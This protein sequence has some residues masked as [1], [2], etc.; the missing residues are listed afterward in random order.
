[1]RPGGTGGR[2]AVRT[3]PW[4]LA[5]ASLGACGGDKSSATGP[6]AEEL[7]FLLQHNARFNGGQTVRWPR[8][9][10]RVFANDIAQ[11][12]EVNEWA[13]ATGGAVGF[14]FV[15]SA[16]GADITFRF[17]SGDDICGATT[18]R[19]NG[20]GEI[21]S[22]DVEVVRAIY[23]GPRCQRTV[24]HEV[25]HAIGFLDHTEDGGLMDR[26]G[27]NGEFT[28][29]VTT[30]IRNLYA[31]APGTLIG[32]TRAPGTPLRPRSGSV[33]IVDYPR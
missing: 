18:V 8:L 29:P 4:L 16:S 10:I 1:V 6:S 24:V 20:G 22:A 28:D 3:L 26:D 33:R 25:G 11:P 14:T 31:L 17:G 9:P 23:R 13:G 21:T 2:W 12:G 30:M 19:W 27:G 5:L 15:G 32:N 7:Q